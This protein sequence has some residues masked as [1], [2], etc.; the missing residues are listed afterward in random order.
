MTS[1]PSPAPG[2]AGP[3]GEPS[4]ASRTTPL[5]PAVL[6]LDGRPCLVV[7]GGPVAARK[8]RSLL[9]CGAT[10]TVIAPE[11]TEAIETALRAEER[12]AGGRPPALRVCR[13]PY[14]RGDVAGHWLAIA[15]TGVRA[16]DR[17]VF[18]DG[19]ALRV[20]VNAADDP[21]SCSLMLPAVLRRGP[22][23]VAV[24]TSGSSPALARWLRDRIAAVAGP[25]LAELACLLAE[26]RDRLHAAGLSTQGTD[27][28]ELLDGGLAELASRGDSTDVRAVA[29]RWLD[30]RLRGA[31]DAPRQGHAG[32]RG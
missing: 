28:G 19:E 23:S 30:A 21:A 15:A 26:L 14:R 31:S 17:A 25:E 24:S 32:S 4:P 1:A 29:G 6:D 7:G 12:R 2:S 5:F 18:E 3:R 13:R 27:W 20:F 11:V 22:V 9:D 10:V 8:V 16:V